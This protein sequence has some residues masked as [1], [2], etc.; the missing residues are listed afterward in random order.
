MDERSPVELKG[1]DACF[2]SANRGW[3]VVI[4]VEAAGVKSR[5]G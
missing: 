4:G 3:G 5:E 1:R 2:F